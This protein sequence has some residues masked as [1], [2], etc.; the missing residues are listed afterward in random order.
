MNR[1]DYGYIMHCLGPSAVAVNRPRG[2]RQAGGVTIGRRLDLGKL[3]ET[4]IRRLAAPSSLKSKLKP[5]V[6]KTGAEAVAAWRWQ[7]LRL[8]STERAAVLKLESEDRI[9]RLAARYMSAAN[10]KKRRSFGSLPPDAQTALAVLELASSTRIEQTL[11]KLWRA[12]T[13]QDWA[14]ATKALSTARLPGLGPRAVS[15]LFESAA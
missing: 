9:N 6:G 13:A 2:T 8:S 5:Y 1:I 11:P 7:P 10:N 12:A 3:S 15:R 4:D 14:A